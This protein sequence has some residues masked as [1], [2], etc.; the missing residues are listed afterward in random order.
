M[1]GTAPRQREQEVQGSCGCSGFPFQGWLG[2][3]GLEQ[4]GVKEAR[5]DDG[6]GQK[7]ALRALEVWAREALSE[8]KMDL[9]VPCDTPARSQRPGS[10][11]RMAIDRR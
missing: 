11:Q 2:G 8:G 5:G 10:G 7:V 6:R 3:L 4:R 1:G 9:R